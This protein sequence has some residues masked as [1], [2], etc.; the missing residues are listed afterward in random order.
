MAH[1]GQESFRTLW[2]FLFSFFF[3]G[4]CTEY[5]IRGPP[6]FLT[7]TIRV[8]FRA[9]LEITGPVFQFDVWQQLH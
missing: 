1:G 8:V 4:D 2:T 5:R 9:V 7:A 6:H 3:F